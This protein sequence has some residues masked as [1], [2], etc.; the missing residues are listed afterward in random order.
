MNTVLDHEIFLT[1]MSLFASFSCNSVYRTHSW[2]LDG[3]IASIKTT[4][5][6]MTTT[7]VPFSRALSS[8][9]C[10]NHARGT[11]LFLLGMRLELKPQEKKSLETNGKRE[12][13][14][15]SLTRDAGN[16][17]PIK[18]SCH[19]TAETVKTILFPSSYT[20]SSCTVVCDI[21]RAKEVT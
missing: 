10:R 20:F 12:G 8:R 17:R 3:C 15:G 7:K 6:T 5:T 4:T 2:S 19:G 16:R 13:K 9:D 21:L 18:L 14:R 11:R 1:L